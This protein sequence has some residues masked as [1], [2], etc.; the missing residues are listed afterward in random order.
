MY[1]ILFLTC[2]AMAIIVGSAASHAATAITI[3]YGTVES[4]ITTTEESSHAGGAV[5]GG[6]MRA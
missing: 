1:K 5:A 6:L 3:N 4:A 2:A